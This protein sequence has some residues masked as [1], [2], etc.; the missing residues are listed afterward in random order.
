[1]QRSPTRPVLPSASNLANRWSLFGLA[2]AATR[3]SSPLRRSPR[4]PL[5]DGGPEHLV[6]GYF[7]RIVVDE[8]HRI[9]GPKTKGHKPIVEIN[10]ESYII[11]TGTLLPNKL[12]DFE[13]V[14]RNFWRGD[15]VL[16]R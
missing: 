13:G 6:Q 9:K 3:P 8:G 7:G 16:E 14:L 1:M 5:E 2:K 12:K 15:Y 11:L 10:A 4:T